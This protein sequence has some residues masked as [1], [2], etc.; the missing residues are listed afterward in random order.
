MIKIVTASGLLLALIAASGH[1]GVYKSRDADGNVTYS[2]SPQSGAIE[3]SVIATPPPPTAE[4]VEASQARERE[5]SEA[6]SQASASADARVANRAALRTQLDDAKQAL[7]SAQAARVAGEEPL[8]GERRGL[9][10]GGTRLT[11]E[12]HARQ[13]QLEDAVSAAEQNLRQAEENWRRQS[14]Q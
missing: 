14:A 11:E 6:A 13:G 1:A 5:I 3:E 8:P 7:E 4:E 2:D 9:A 12:Y 10:G